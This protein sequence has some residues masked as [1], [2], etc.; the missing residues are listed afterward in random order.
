MRHTPRS[1][2]SRRLASGPF[3]AAC[4]SALEGA[5]VEARGLKEP[6]R[7]PQSPARRAPPRALAAFEAGFAL[8]DEGA[9]RRLE[10]LAQ[11]QT[12][13]L[14]VVAGLALHLVDEP[15]HDPNVGADGQRRVLE[16]L[17]GQRLGG[18]DQ[19]SLRYDAVHHA[20]L[21]RLLGGEHAAGQRDLVRETAAGPEA[22]R[23]PTL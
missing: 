21:V 15:P 7:P 5:A 13:A 10:V 17:R 8:L 9:V 16:D 3:C 14:R 23:A 6:S 12:E 22:S 11:V 18:G 1:G 20:V 2:L 19:L 4:M